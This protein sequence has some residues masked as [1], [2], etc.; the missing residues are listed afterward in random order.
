MQQIKLKLA[1]VLKLGK[2]CMP[3]CLGRYT[4]YNPV[5]C[6]NLRLLCYV[7]VGF[8][9]HSDLLLDAAEGYRKW[10]KHYHAISRLVSSHLSLN[11]EGRRRATNDFATSFLHFSLFP[12][13]LWD[14]GNSRPVQSLLLS[15]RL[16]LCL[17][18][19]LPPFTVPWFI[20][21][22]E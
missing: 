19:L 1:L 5:P 17:P 9:P 8:V 14:L 4:L 20:T 21:R 10:I 6:V 2:K 15:S 3:F 16:F 22:L 11:R 12:N 13:A 18:C 7:I